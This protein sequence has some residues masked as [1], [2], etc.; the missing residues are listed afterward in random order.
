MMDMQRF[1]KRQTVRKLGRAGLGP[2]SSVR[3]P[4][5]LS[6]SVPDE[7]RAPPALGDSTEAVLREMG[8][9]E[10]KIKILLDEGVA[11]ASA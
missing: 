3:S 5:R 7:G 4:V 11:A 1:A 6:N 8:L 2:V 10:E 9:T